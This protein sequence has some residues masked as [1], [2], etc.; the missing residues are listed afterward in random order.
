MG[1]YTQEL[2]IEEIVTLVM[3]LGNIYMLH[4]KHSS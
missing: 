2:P 4:L 3:Q 1:K